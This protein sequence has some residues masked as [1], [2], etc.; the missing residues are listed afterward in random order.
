LERG[1]SQTSA[2]DLGCL[3]LGCL[4]TSMK[5][6]LMGATPERQTLRGTA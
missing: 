3:F 1:G 2:E 4:F 6:E 5:R